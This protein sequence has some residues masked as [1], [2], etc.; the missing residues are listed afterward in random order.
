[1]EKERIVLPKQRKLKKVENEAFNF[2][3]WKE[4]KWK[5]CSVREKN[6]VLRV[7]LKRSVKRVKGYSL[8]DFIYTRRFNAWEK[9]SNHKLIMI[10]VLIFY[11]ASFLNGLFSA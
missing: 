7:I 8:Q 9:T 5:F 1:M 3:L 2:Y 4:G 11:K 10:L 6:S